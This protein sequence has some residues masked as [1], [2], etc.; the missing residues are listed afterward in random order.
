MI[1]FFQKSFFVLQ[2]KYIK[3]DE[4]KRN[5]LGKTEDRKL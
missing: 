5:I 1:F 4:R 3:L 2:K